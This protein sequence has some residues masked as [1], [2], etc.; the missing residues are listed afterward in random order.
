M[1]KILFIGLVVTAV[2]L[3]SGCYGPTTSPNATVQPTG[4]TPG[5]IT[6]VITPIE[7]VMPI[8]TATS[9]GITNVTGTPAATSTAGPIVTYTPLATWTPMPT[10]TGTVTGTSSAI[11][12]ISTVTGTATA[13]MTVVTTSSVEIRNSAFNP[14]IISVPTGTTVTWTNRDNITH[15]VT[16]SGFDSGRLDSGQTFSRTFS[17]AGTYDYKCSIHP[18]MSGTVAVT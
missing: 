10:V 13:A 2:V 18:N 14:A 7:T 11:T 17:T 12:P 4:G 3:V 5:K 6:P 16:G 8:E 15:T 9:V 1:R